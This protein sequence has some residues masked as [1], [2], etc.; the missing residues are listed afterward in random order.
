ME[1]DGL[2]NT[3][4][5]MIVALF[6]HLEDIIHSLCIKENNRSHDIYS[7][8]SSCIQKENRDNPEYIYYYAPLYWEWNVPEMSSLYEVYTGVISLVIV[9]EM[10]S[11]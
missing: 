1:V 8:G 4:M 9:V 10:P 2:G 6:S 7:K 3:G 11:S 5:V